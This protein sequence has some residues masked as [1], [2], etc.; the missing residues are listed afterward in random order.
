M[1]TKGVSTGLWSAGA[2]ALALALVLGA[3]GC[4]GDRS[5]APPRQ[6]FP[7]MDDGPKW[8]PQTRSEF[9]ADGRTMRLPPAGTVPFGPLLHAGV[10]FMEP[11]EWAQT[12]LH[13]R[14]AALKEDDRLYKGQEGAGVDEKGNAVV[15]YVEKIPI[16]VTQA[17]LARGQQRFDIYCAVCHGYTGDGKGEVGK[18][19]AYPLPTYHDPKYRDPA[20]NT[21]R[22]G[23]L[24]HVSREGVYDV[25]GNQKMPGYAHALSEED[26]WAIVAY[27]R[28]LQTA[29]DG[30]LG[31]VP[32]EQ[33]EALERQRTLPPPAP[34]AVPAPA[35]PMPTSAQPAPAATGGQP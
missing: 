27:I 4:R 31:D 18:S 7:D 8:R 15:H 17:L 12:T 33:R 21:G 19:W 28:A 2:G 26:S 11:P 9:Y 16:P 34:A 1:H 20:Q 22:D 6:F 10:V 5:D 35:Q 32:R 30:S 3:G 23:Y 13:A 25:N 14:D 24:F 29:R